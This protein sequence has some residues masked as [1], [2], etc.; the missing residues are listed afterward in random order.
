MGCASFDE[1]DDAAGFSSGHD[2]HDIKNSREEP[3]GAD[4]DKASPHPGGEPDPSSHHSEADGEQVCAEEGREGPVAVEVAGSVGY[5][6]TGSGEETEQDTAPGQH[7]SRHNGRPSAPTGQALQED[8]AREDDET[9]DEE[10][11]V[12]QPVERREHVLLE[13]GRRSLDPEVADHVAGIAVGDVDPCG[14]DDEFDEEENGG[15]GDEQ[16]ARC[17]PLNEEGLSDCL[18]CGWLID[19]IHDWLPFRL[20]GRGRQKKRLPCLRALR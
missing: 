9:V 17:P 10:T 15:T 3:D 1:A 5:G 19:A 6:F 20:F 4:D 7:D 16:D 13:E 11:D 18:G 8:D 12:H 2:E 14:G